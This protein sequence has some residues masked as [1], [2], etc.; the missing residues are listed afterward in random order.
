MKQTPEVL[1]PAM[2]LGAG[3][4]GMS[5][6]IVLII[7]AVV[8]LLGVAAIQIA[9][10]SVRSARNDRDQQIAW[11]SA[12]AAL[13]DA[14]FDLFGPTPS[15]RRDLFGNKPDLTAFALGCG[16]S[17]NSVG[18]C[19]PADTGRPAWMTVDFEATGSAAPTAALGAF[20]D[21]SFPAGGPGIQPAQAPRY[22]IEAIR[23]PNDR[24]LS[25]TE[26]K[27]IYRVTAMGFGPRMD[28]QAVL[29]MIYRI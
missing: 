6:V 19:I 26:P 12:E 27:Y 21:R 2:R 25:S 17:G 14:E 5:L 24:D 16:T 15:S 11:Q 7:L 8:S 1:P 28:I 9:G 13:I 3:Q 10:M 29:Q 23:D 22:I 20:T 18:L 4:R